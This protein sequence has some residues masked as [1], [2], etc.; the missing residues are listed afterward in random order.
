MTFSNSAKPD[1][2]LVMSEI[3]QK[4]YMSVGCFEIFFDEIFAMK[5]KANELMIQY[6]LNP[7]YKK[8]HMIYQDYNWFS[9]YK[10]TDPRICGKPDSTIF[11]RSEGNEMLYMVNKC[12]KS[13]GWSH[14]LF[15]MQRLENI[16]REKV[17]AEV[18]TQIEV[19]NWIQ[20]NC[21]RI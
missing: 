7:S 10:K 18:Q 15:A 19:Y 16:I 20:N 8:E 13:W 4:G 9:K 1:V 2:V 5:V 17:P 11:S 21:D 3:P 12:G 6:F 14:D